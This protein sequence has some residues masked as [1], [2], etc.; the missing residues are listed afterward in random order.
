MADA[1]L[2]AVWDVVRDPTLVGEWS[3]ECHGAVWVE[4][5]TGAAP[6]A[7]F[8]GRNRVGHSRWSRTSE[9]VAVEAPRKLVWRT[10]P[11][12]IY[13]DSTEWT[14]ELEPSDTGTRIE[15][16]FRVLAI[17]TVHG[18]ACS[19]CSSPRTATAALRSRATCSGWARSPPGGRTGHDSRMSYVLLDRPRPHVALITLNRPERMN[20]MAFHVMVPFREMLEAISVDN[21]VRV[22]VHHRRRPRVLLRRRPDQRRRCACPTSTA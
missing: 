22:V 15:Q 2:E 9:V 14:I 3:H 18:P 20:S 19:R 21:D 6:G 10:V 8:Q 7:R 17:S 11:S 5:A 16:R 12:P 13:R 1:P 4:G